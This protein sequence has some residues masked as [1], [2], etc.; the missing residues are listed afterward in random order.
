M[1]SVASF[2]L[3]QRLVAGAAS[4]MN[5]SHSSRFPLSSEP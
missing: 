1:S 4:V 2:D 3:Q 5:D